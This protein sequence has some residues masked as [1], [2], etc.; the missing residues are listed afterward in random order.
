MV[1]ETLV[2]TRDIIKNYG[3]CQNWFTNAAGNVC[4]SHAIHMAVGKVPNS[5]DYEAARSIL[6]YVIN[7]GATR[8]YVSVPHF[9][10]APGRTVVEVLDVLGKAI[11]YVK[12]GT[13]E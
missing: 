10:D 5:P 6:M 9:N 4:L 11:Q 12:N 13:P 1:L 8:T 3:W 2:K 7:R